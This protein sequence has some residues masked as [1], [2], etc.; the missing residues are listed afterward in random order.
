MNHKHLTENLLVEKK[1]RV[2]PEIHRLYASKLGAPKLIYL[3]LWDWEN[4]P[5]WS[6]VHRT[7]YILITKNKTPPEKT[8]G[9]TK[10][11]KTE[12]T[13]SLSAF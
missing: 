13:H 8:H 4:L 12:K 5:E 3:S 11:Y 10:L 9:N 1:S 2:H 6:I 7:F